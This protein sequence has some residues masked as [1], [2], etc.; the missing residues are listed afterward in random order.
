MPTLEEI[1]SREVLTSGADASIAE[2][3]TAMLKAQVGSAIVMDGTY[4]VGIFTERDVVRAAAAGSDPSSTP[5]SE[6]MTPDPVTATPDTEAEEAAEIMMS[7]GFR[8]LPVVRGTDL[9][10]IASLRDILRTRIRR[11]TG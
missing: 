3:A 2:A 8:H 11:R 1:M 4:L 9:V 7:Q 10:G 5:V 6:W